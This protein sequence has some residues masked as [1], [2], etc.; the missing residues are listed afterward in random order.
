MGW[1]SA[2]PSFWQ[3]VCLGKKDREAAFGSHFYSMPCAIIVFCLRGEK[4]KKLAEEW[5]EPFCSREAASRGSLCWGSGEGS[6]CP[7][8]PLLAR[9]SAG[10]RGTDTGRR[11][12]QEERCD[13]PLQLVSAATASREGPCPGLQEPLGVQ[14]GKGQLSC[15][16]EP[17]GDEMTSRY[18]YHRSPQ[19]PGPL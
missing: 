2:G 8:P 6:R 13:F 14:W 4:R 18:Q 3:H 12:A 16:L 10:P 5:P 7:L 9:L 15:W 17:A 11:K 19:P 1:F